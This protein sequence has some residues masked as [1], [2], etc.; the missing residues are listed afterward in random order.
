MLQLAVASFMVT[1]TVLIHLGGLSVLLELMVRRRRRPAGRNL[2]GQSS[3]IV[4]AAFALFALHSIEIW[5]Y[6]FLYVLVHALGSF[7]DALYFSTAT[8]STVGY[9]DLTLP[10]AWR[11]VGAIEGAN[12]LLLLGW[13]TAFFVSIV[14]EIRKLESAA[15]RTQLPGEAEPAALRD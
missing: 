8:Y 4:F 11:L 9:G 12:G 5:L 10:R 6:A 2:F 1:I 3:A 15:D 7:E 14:D 13:S